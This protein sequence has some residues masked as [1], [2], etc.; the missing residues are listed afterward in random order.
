MPDIWENIISMSAGNLNSVLLQL[1][2][3]NETFNTNLQETFNNPYS[4]LLCS[5]QYSPLEQIKVSKQLCRI[6]GGL[7]F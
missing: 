2:C 6:K 4:G 7:E 5:V 3:F 1:Y